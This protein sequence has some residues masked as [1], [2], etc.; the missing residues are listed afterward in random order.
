M[1]EGH[2]LFDKSVIDGAVGMTPPNYNGV[3]N[4]L[5]GI[6]VSIKCTWYIKVQRSGQ[7][8]VCIYI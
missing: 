4:Y 8:E 3:V 2:D 6:F 1:K 7:K 5:I